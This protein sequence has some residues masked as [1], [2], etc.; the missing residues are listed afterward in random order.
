M[1]HPKEEIDT[2]Y[3]AAH[4]TRESSGG[5]TKDLQESSDEGET[6]VD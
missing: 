2:E 3:E 5:D 1:T 6:E 4:V